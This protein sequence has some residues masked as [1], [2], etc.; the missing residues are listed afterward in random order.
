MQQGYSRDCT[1]CRH[2]RR[3]HSA[4]LSRHQYVMSKDARI[5]GRCLALMPT[6]ALAKGSSS[7]PSTS[8]R[9][10]QHQ[11][12]AMRAIDPNAMH[13]NSVHKTPR[14]LIVVETILVLV[15][16]CQ[17]SL[18]LPFARLPCAPAPCTHSIHPPQC[19]PRRP[20]ASQV[21]A[22][23]H[24]NPPIGLTRPLPMPPLQSHMDHPRLPRLPIPVNTSSFEM[25]SPIA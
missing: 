9:N 4:S 17:Q 7:P 11:D 14:H 12:P 1:G 15:D 22:C 10:C 18:H 6:W 23:S 25:E 24:D 2:A 13:T 3:V 19:A 21:P 5:V 8:S 16:H 20:Q